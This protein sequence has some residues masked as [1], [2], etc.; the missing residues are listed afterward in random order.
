MRPGCLIIAL[1]A[2]LLGCGNAS[3]AEWRAL[4]S[5]PLKRTEVAAARVGD[6]I[7]VVGGFV[8]AGHTTAAVELYDIARNR[9]SRARSM[10]VALNHAAIAVYRNDI[11]V[12]GG[13]E[14][15]NRA[16]AHLLRYDPD[17]NRWTRLAK[18]PTK[19]GALTAGVIGD[20]L[21]AAGG[22]DEGK[23]LTTLEVY[24]FKTRRWSPG[25]PMGVAREHLG[26]AV[27]NAASMSSPAARRAS[28]T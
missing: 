4:K 3:A 9:W 5:S 8:S 18:M 14:D 19:R 11:Y 13:Y 23:A 16:T 28:A 12:V 20:R 24:D 15:P 1:A 27:S 26:G 2:V 10:P 6:R 7:Y 17:T 21:Y 22:A 25:P